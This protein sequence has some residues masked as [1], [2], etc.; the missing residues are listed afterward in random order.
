MFCGAVNS[1]HAGI[2]PAE[3]PKS[4]NTTHTL[5]VRRET[6]ELVWAYYRIPDPAVRRWLAELTKAVVRGEAE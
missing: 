2:S 6:L 1:S 5:M 4:G 3:V